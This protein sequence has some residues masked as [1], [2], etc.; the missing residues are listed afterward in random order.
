MKAA[1]QLM[2]LVPALFLCGAGVRA[3]Q[4]TTNAAASPSEPR[5]ALTEATTAFDALGREALGGQ[6]RTTQLAGTPDAPGRNVLL[7]VENR[8]QVFY[9]YASGYATF[10]GSDGVRCGEGM[11]K[12]DALAPGERVEVDTPGLR[13]TCTPTTWRLSALNLVPRTP[14]A[15]KPAAAPTPPTTNAAP[16]SAAG[17]PQ[18]LEIN[19]NGKTLPLQLGNPVDIVVGKERVLIVV[20]PAP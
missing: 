10:Y 13:L 9:N 12:T 2:L 3:Q 14:D 5:V 20:Q 6:L 15:T 7:V 17:T 18:R 19:I 11:W 1:K 8:S 16:T 4:A